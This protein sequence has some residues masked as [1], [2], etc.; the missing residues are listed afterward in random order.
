MAYP[1]ESG[2]FATGADAPPPPPPP[3]LPPELAGTLARLEGAG[4]APPRR[5]AARASRTATRAVWS[6]V[7]AGA[8]ALLLL[9][10]LLAQNTRDV[11]LSF[12]WMHARV[13]LG[14]ALLLAGC[15]GVCVAVAAV[16]LYL[17]RRSRRARRR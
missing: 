14:L 5:R 12:L 17:I 8:A 10:V 9:L 11:P 2:P 15:C 16:S 3:P 13:P 4:T 1:S 6:G 7:W